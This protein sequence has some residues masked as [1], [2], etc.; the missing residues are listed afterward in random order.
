MEIIAGR[1]PVLEALRGNRK[2]K[3]ILLAQGLKE[4]FALGE[5]KKLAK[6]KATPLQVIERKILDDLCHDSVHQGILV[7]AEPISYLHL[8]DF[9]EPLSE[10]EIIVLLLDEITDPQNLGSLIRTAEAAG[11]KGIVVTKRR[12]VG[13]TPAVVKASAGA[14]EHIPLVRVSNLVVS[15]EEFKK[16]G[17]WIVGADMASEKIYFEADLRERLCLV[18]GSE[19]RGLSRL[20]KE[21]CDFL[22][23]IPMYGKV[24]SL[25]VAVAGAI[26]MFEARRQLMA[27]G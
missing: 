27:N 8:K 10:K 12:S 24:S 13:I 9:L 3:K 1:N 6:E 4:S 2:I 11:V 22:V 5:I 23:K 16:A 25:N 7:Y 18:L 17:F 20:V 19:G 21:K 15:I 14:I 26:L